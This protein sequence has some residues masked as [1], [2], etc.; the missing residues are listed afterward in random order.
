MQGCRN[1]LYAG[2]VRALG[3][4]ECGALPEK[5]L[6][7]RRLPRRVNF[8]YRVLDHSSETQKRKWHDG[9]VR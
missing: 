4:T 7:F 1:V 2:S 8:D 3:T 5:A 6:N 9:N